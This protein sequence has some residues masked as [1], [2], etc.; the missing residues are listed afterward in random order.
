MVS[1]HDP[2]AGVRR[3]AILELGGW[4]SD[5]ALDAI[6]AVL[7]SPSTAPYEAALAAVSIAITARADRAVC[8]CAET[9]IRS[10]RDSQDPLDR[11]AASVAV[12]ASAI[13][14]ARSRESELLNEAF[15]MTLELE[16]I[17]SE[18]SRAIAIRRA[19]LNA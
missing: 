3:H 15:A 10:A 5:Q 13:I 12:L 7:R 6:D 9:L 16:S 17:D 4:Q 19:L 8:D 11:L 1:L 14:A 18:S 2:S